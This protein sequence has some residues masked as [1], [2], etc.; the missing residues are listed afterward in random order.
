MLIL[1][2]KGKRYAVRG[3]IDLFDSYK[4]TVDENTPLEEEVALDPELLRQG[5]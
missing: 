1:A 5:V 3:L 2:R 4:F